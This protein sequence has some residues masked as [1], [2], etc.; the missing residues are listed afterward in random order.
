ML[1]KLYDL[2]KFQ[3]NLY[4]P[5]QQ[6]PQQ[7]MRPMMPPMMQPQMGQPMQQQQMQQPNQPPANNIQLDL[8]GA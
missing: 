5:Q 3:T 8:F 4:F 6:M 7:G 1:I 2:Y